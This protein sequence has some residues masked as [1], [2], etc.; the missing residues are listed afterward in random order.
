M[1]EMAPLSL[2]PHAIHLFLEQVSHGLWDNGKRNHVGLVRQTQH[3][4]EAGPTQ[5]ASAFADLDLDT[6]AFPDYSHQ[7]PHDAWTVGFATGSP[8]IFINHRDNQEQH[9]P[10]GSLVDHNLEEQ[11]RS[12]FGRIVRGQEDLERILLTQTTTHDYFQE[13]ISILRATILEPSSSSSSTETLDYEQLL[14]ALRENT[15]ST[16]TVNED[17]EEI[18]EPNEIVFGR[19][20]RE[21]LSS[22]LEDETVL[23]MTP[24]SSAFEHDQ[25]KGDKEQGLPQEDSMI[26]DE[27]ALQRLRDFNSWNER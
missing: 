8:H 4:L 22:P 14:Q 7:Y 27:E 20:L 16:D 10:H 26:H 6:V 2:V 17:M 15:A 19:T 23:G 11:G 18:P 21:I 3:I 24:I 5:D 9:G 1:L 13:P 25:A 12:C